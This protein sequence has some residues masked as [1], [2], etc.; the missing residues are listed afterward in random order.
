MWKLQERKLLIKEMPLVKGITAV[1][2]IPI[3][4]SFLLPFLLAV[5]YQLLSFWL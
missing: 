3:N 1:P 2:I 4:V 5:N